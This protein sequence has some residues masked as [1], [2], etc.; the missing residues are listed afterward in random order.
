KR[1]T[2]WSTLAAGLQEYMLQRPDM[3]VA[4]YWPKTSH[5]IN[6]RPK[7]V[8]AECGDNLSLKELA[9]FV[10]QVY[11]TEP[12]LGDPGNKYR[13]AFH[14]AQNCYKEDSLLKVIAFLPEPNE[15]LSV[16]KD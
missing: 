11:R 5:L 7:Q 3:R 13:G 1:H 9:G 12:W 8:V 15:D 4:I 16:V 10:R 2:P 14:K 6:Y